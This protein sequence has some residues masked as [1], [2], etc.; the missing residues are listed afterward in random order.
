MFA[1]ASAYGTIDFDAIEEYLRT[2]F[3]YVE[4]D[5]GGNPGLG[6]S[7]LVGTNQD[8]VIKLDIYYAM[9]PFFQKLTEEE[10][11]RMATVE[12]IIAMKV[13]IIQRGGRKKDFWDLHEALDRYSINKM[14]TLHRL[15]FEWTHNEML[16]LNNFTAFTECDD[17]LEPLCLRGKQW[18]F[19][20]EDFAEAVAN[21]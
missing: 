5:F 20:K 8:E 4:G 10:K 3:A 6:K 7:Y 15:R 21:R 12:E 9:D 2:N 19:I 14:I 17:D 13:D 18:A 11:V 16:I 1:D